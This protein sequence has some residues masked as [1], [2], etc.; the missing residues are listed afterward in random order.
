MVLNIESIGSKNHT[1][2]I[3][4]RKISAFI[5]S[6]LPIFS[7]YAIWGSIPLN[8]MLLGLILFYFFIINMKLK[9]NMAFPI[10][11]LWVF[12]LILSLISTFFYTFDISL[13]NSLIFISISIVTISILWSF[14]D[15]DTFTTYANLIG[16]ISCIFLFIQAIFLVM[17]AEAPSGK[18]VGLELLDYSSFVS[19]TWGFRLNSFFQEPS[20][21]AIYILPLLAINLKKSNWK[22]ATF[23][24]IA[25]LLSS[26][27]LGILGAIFI[28]FYYLLFENKNIKSFLLF[29]TLFFVIHLAFYYTV[30]FYNTSINRSMEKI[31]YLHEY[32]SI[33]FLGQI[34]MFMLLPFYHQLF[35]VGVNQMQNYFSAMGYFVHN[36]SNS[37]VITLINTGTIGFIVY[38]CFIVFSYFK[39]KSNKKEIFIF[40]FILIASVDY[41]IYNAFFFYL[42]AFIY[43]KNESRFNNENF[44][45]NT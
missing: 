3:R 35:G 17:G 15:F 21:F 22:L 45:Y 1:S 2:V 18:L 37:F 8:F 7:P 13:I 23:Y 14:C 26:S 44:V 5:L 42:L 40:I 36:Y 16:F 6:V 27:S 34:N 29:I 41:L 20:Y 11:L 24:T 25:L 43:L 10:I 38:I 39:S 12:H 33:R 9:I 19:T 31:M 4:R 28:I 30:G 32:S